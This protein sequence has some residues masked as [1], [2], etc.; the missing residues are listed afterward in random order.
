MHYILLL[1]ETHRWVREAV[2]CEQHILFH[3]FLVQAGHFTLHSFS[4]LRVHHWGNCILPFEQTG[5]YFQRCFPDFYHLVYVGELISVEST[6]TRKHTCW[7]VTVSRMRREAESCLSHIMTRLLF[8][9]QK[10]EGFHP[11]SS[12]HS[13]SL[14][15]IDKNHPT[16]KTTA[17]DTSS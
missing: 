4:F 7:K 3:F 5:S 16:F 11:H 1:S 10:L 14:L 15:F 2:I 9:F 6:L 12:A 17:E 8:S 13:H